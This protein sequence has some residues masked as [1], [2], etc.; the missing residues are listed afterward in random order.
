M[1]LISIEMVKAEHRPYS[2][3]RASSAFSRFF[4]VTPTCEGPHE[5]GFCAGADGQNR[6]TGNG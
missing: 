5:F 3:L 6:V 4:Q 2:Q 1:S